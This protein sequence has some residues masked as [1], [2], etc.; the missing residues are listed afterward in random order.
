MAMPTL[1]L[2]KSLIDRETDARFWAQTGYKVGQKLDPSNPT[3]R[4]MSKV[5]LDI[6]GKVKREDRDGTLVTT[7]NH[8][9]VERSLDDAAIASHAAAGHLDAAAQEADPD[10]SQS[11][12]DAAAGASASAAA[13]ARR[14]AALQPPTVSPI[15]ADAA[16]AASAAA[17]VFPF[18]GPLV[19]TLSQD[20]PAVSS[21]AAQ[22]VLP[23]SVVSEATADSM[24]PPF[25]GP[26]GEGRG[27]GQPPG[28]SPPS[29]V[30]YPAASLF[31]PFGPIDPGQSG[32]PAAPQPASPPRSVVADPASSAFPPFGPV[33][34]SQVPATP[35]DQLAVAQA[36]SSPSVAVKIHED[37]HGRASRGD[38]RPDGT[39]HPKTSGSIRELARRLAE[40]SNGNFVGV[41]YQPNEEWSVPLFS[42]ASEAGA[43]YEH[44]TDTPDMFKYVAY[45]DK[46]SPAWPRCVSEIFGSARAISPAAGSSPAARDEDPAVDPSQGY[47]P[48]PQGYAPAPQGYAPA[49]FAA[50]APTSAPART[51]APASDGGVSRGTLAAIGAVAV[52]GVLTIF[53]GRKKRA[54]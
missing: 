30:S 34:Q 26:L 7:Y 40:D 44:L 14:A 8:P 19:S 45:F 25:V 27:S 1:H 42:S 35:R 32:Q 50:S 39:M 49:R 10:V 38:P 46:T 6:W 24:F 41:N 16:A 28:S 3:D 51:S 11:H 22:P 33:D 48:A 20:H 18:L 54:L 43:W 13:A 12:V 47:A 23:P 15:V 31:P 5:W 4:E 9:E 52:A 36:V 37:A 17:A 2:S 29:A 21:P 53:A